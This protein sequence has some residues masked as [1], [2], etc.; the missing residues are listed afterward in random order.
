[1]IDQDL[2]RHHG[3]IAETLNRLATLPAD[4]RLSALNIVLR[5]LDTMSG[6][7]KATQDQMAMSY[8]R[9]QPIRP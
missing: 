7:V 2:S 4:A 5:E 9:S 3:R 8:A 6:I 1:M